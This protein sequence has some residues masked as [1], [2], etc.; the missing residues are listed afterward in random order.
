MPEFGVPGQGAAAWGVLFPL[1]GASHSTDEEEANPQALASGKWEA[2]CGP[3]QSQRQTNPL[4]VLARLLVQEQQA[5][6]QNPF[7]G[8]ISFHSLVPLKEEWDL[9]S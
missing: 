1:P 2:G 7:Q 4:S 6:S 5:S 3:R 9:A 8:M